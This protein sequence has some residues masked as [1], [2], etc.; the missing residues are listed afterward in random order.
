MYRSPYFR[1]KTSSCIKQTSWC[2]LLCVPL[3]WG[4]LKT[5][6]EC[7]PQS[8]Y[9]SFLTLPVQAI[10]LSCP[11]N[12]EVFSG[13]PASVLTV[14][15]PAPSITFQKTQSVLTTFSCCRTATGLHSPAVKSARGGLPCLC[16]QVEPLSSA[17][18]CSSCTDLQPPCKVIPIWGPGC[19]SPPGVLPLGAGSSLRR[20]V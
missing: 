14:N 1:N 6:G 19:S 10:V 12:G 17:L 3:L 20:S 4:A 5:I 16:S 15:H 9:F 11:N 2:S 13:V 8:L 7:L 18:L